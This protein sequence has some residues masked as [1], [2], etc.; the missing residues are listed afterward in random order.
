[1]VRCW[2][3]ADTL[4]DDGRRPLLGDERTCQKTF[5]GGT[6]IMGA[7]PGVSNLRLSY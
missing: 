1:M 6:K 4:L 5:V 3:E 2:P 7:I